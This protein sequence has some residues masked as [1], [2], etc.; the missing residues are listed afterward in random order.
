MHPQK[1]PLA[2]KIRNQTGWNH[3]WGR[4]NALV[5]NTISTRFASSV[6]A[7]SYEDG[8][9]VPRFLARGWEADSGIVAL[10][11]MKV[12]GPGAVWVKNLQG[13]ASKWVTE[14]RLK[15]NTWE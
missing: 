2:L 15:G 4:I 11:L 5:Y 6:E 13:D 9:L 8:E 1:L 12:F 14:S 3:R 10:V 7:P